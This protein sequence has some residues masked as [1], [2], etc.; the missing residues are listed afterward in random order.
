[1]S[2]PPKD[3]RACQLLNAACGKMGLAVC[4]RDDEQ[5]LSVRDVPF[6][7]PPEVVLALYI[8]LALTVESMLQAA[9][10]ELQNAYP[11]AAPGTFLD[12]FRRT[13]ADEQPPGLDTAIQWLPKKPGGE[14]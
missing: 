10:Q 3:I 6:G 2:M 9:C 1:M 13:L 14:G 12:A 4:I 5:P 11:Q 8:S 7:T